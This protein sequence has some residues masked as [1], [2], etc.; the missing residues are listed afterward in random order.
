MHTYA[1][2]CTYTL[3][4]YWKMWRLFTG[5]D[6]RH[7]LSGLLFPKASPVIVS[8]LFDKNGKQMS[9]SAT[10]VG[11]VLLQSRMLS[12]SLIFPAFTGLEPRIQCE[13]WNVCVFVRERDCERERSVIE[14]GM[15]HCGQKLVCDGVCAGIQVGESEE[16]WRANGRLLNE[17]YINHLKRHRS[18]RSSIISVGNAVQPCPLFLNS[19]SGQ[20]RDKV[21]GFVFTQ[22][23]S[24]SAS[25]CSLIQ[26][27]E[28]SLI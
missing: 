4:N 9:L 23:P 27:C 11:I 3:S 19:V 25:G 21:P 10:S 1:H 16:R 2:I 14:D 6:A 26:S 12:L 17:Q 5:A 18:V 20:R 22:S 8:L 24:N 15:I 13:K 7:F 28:W